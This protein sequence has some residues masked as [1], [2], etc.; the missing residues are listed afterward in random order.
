M[1]DLLTKANAYVAAHRENVDSRY[2]PLY[3]QSV[4]IGWLNDPNG[5]SFFRGEYHL[6]YQFHPYDSVWGPM[7]WGH[8]ASKDLLHWR[9]MPVAMAPD[10]PFDSGGCFSGTALA[11]GDKLMIF[12]TGVTAPDE[13]GKRLQQQC[14]AETLDGIHME[15]YPENPVIGRAQLP[16]GANPYDFRDPKIF[17]AEA[18]YGMILASQGPSG[19]QLLLYRS[20]DLY[21]WRY[22]GVFMDGFGVMSECPDYFALDGREA[23]IAC[24]I[25]MPEEGTRW[26]N[27]RPVVSVIGH[28]DKETGLFQAEEPWCAVDC[29][30]DFYAPQTMEAPDGRRILIGWMLLP[31]RQVPTHTLGHGWAGVMTLPRECHIRQGRLYQQP[32]RELEALRRNEKA[33]AD[34]QIQ[35]DVRLAGMEGSHIELDMELDL[36]EAPRLSLYLMESGAERFEIAYDTKAQVLRVDKSALGF[37][38]V[39]DYRETQ[40]AVSVPLKEGKLRLQVFVD[41]CAVEVFAN[42]GQVALA[43]LAHPKSQGTGVSFHVEGI[44]RAGS[45]RKWDVSMA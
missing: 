28:T 25:R 23:V 44:C 34:Q 3:H 21:T 42:D 15:K 5:F 39:G 33:W 40:S 19:G 27:D 22:A 36:S 31:G 18:G 8:W 17:K 37:P 4:P 10:M 29:G 38:E 7:H 45:I 2:R 11:Q 14:V 16:E 9:E 12:Y 24:A 35:G 41:T 32:I 6:F 1:S 43:S 13:T 20:D 26:P 30:L